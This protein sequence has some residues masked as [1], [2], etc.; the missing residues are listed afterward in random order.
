MLMARKNRKNRS[1]KVQ[2]A[3]ARQLRSLTERPPR[4]ADSY[5]EHMRYAEAQGDPEDAVDR[6]L[7]ADGWNAAD[8]EAAADAAAASLAGASAEADAREDAPT[9]GDFYCTCSAGHGDPDEHADTCDLWESDDFAYGIARWDPDVWQLTEAPLDY[10]GPLE[11]IT[12][13]RNY[14]ADELS[15]IDRGDDAAQGAA[16]AAV[17]PLD[18]YDG[19]PGYWD[20]EAKKWNPGTG[21]YAPGGPAAGV[22]YTGGKGGALTDSRRGTATSAF[23]S[24]WAWKPLCRHASTPFVLPS[25]VTMYATSEYDAWHKANAA[26]P[27]PDVSVYMTNGYEPKRMSYYLPW[28]DYG[29]PETPDEDVLDAAAILLAAAYQGKRAETGCMGGHGRTGSLL[30]IVVLLDDYESGRPV[31]SGPEAVAYVREHHCDQAVEG[32][33]QADYI[34]W[35]RGYMLHALPAQAALPGMPA[36]ERAPAP[37]P[38]PTFAAAATTTT[39]GNGYTVTTHTAAKS[40]GVL[41]SAPKL[42]TGK[43]T[44][45]AGPL[46]GTLTKPKAAVAAGQEAR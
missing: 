17:T 18:G 12:G 16:A 31:R 46:A 24:D 27:V 41:N 37:G 22:Y 32:K 23:S 38:R 42:P 33:R 19:T 8:L 11:V 1:G 40:S 30:A 5:A 14:T 21:E 29:L 34:A 20:S 2:D 4:P 44:P 13:N 3:A 10:L 39:A 25:G 35:F 9:F 43:G 15:A 7:D 36:P 6:L 28:T 26:R 45:E